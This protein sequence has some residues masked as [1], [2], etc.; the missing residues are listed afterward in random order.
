MSRVILG[1]GHTYI[2][3]YTGTIPADATLE[4]DAN[5]LG[6]TSGGA[7][8]EYA[9]ETYTAKSDD[10]ATTKTITTSEDVTLKTGIMSLDPAML[11]KLVSTARVATDNTTGV[12]TLSIGG[13]GNDNGK[14]YVIRFVHHDEEDGDVRVT[15]VGKNTA[16]FSFSF[17]KDSE[18]IVEPTFT[19]KAMDSSGTLVTFA[20]SEPEE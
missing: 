6:A 8:I 4:V 10:G 13:I 15:I 18:T 19:A 20:F 17:A 14:N 1:S 7:T 16:G 3:E 12:T 9:Q 11:A 2:A 5:L